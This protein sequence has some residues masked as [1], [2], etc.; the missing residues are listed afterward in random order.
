[1][2][3]S[4][5]RLVALRV[6]LDTL[7]DSVEAELAKGSARDPTLVKS[8]EKQID[9]VQA[10]LRQ[11][12][13]CQA[14]KVVKRVEILETRVTAF[15]KSMSKGKVIVQAMPNRLPRVCVVEPSHQHLYEY[16]AQSH[17]EPREYPLAGFTPEGRV[18]VLAN[19]LVEVGLTIKKLQTELQKHE[20]PSGWLVN[21]HLLSII[22][23]LQNLLDNVARLCQ[24]Q[25]PVEAFVD[26]NIYFHEYHF[27][28][29]SF[30]EL[31]PMQKYVDSVVYNNQPWQHF[32]NAFKH[33]APWVGL[34][35]QHPRTEVMD[36]HDSNRVGVVY[37]VCVPVY[38]KLKAMISILGKP[39]KMCL[40]F[41]NV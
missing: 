3:V 14:E 40:G 35:N 22:P 33:S 29:A 20:G 31:A 38:K 9:N 23:G 36:V 1:M 18:A 30:V 37:G 24:E 17:R 25:E 41:P 19:A 28:N 15:E 32:A 12:D 21:A 16:Y 4:A 34:P 10:E 13:C 2:A 39:Y 26:T 5:E 11:H 27:T 7:R 8:Y 6:R